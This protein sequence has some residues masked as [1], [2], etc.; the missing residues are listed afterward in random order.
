MVAPA[1]YVKL[2]LF[3]ELTGYTPKAVHRKKEEGH[4]LLGKQLR[5][6]PDGNLLVDMDEYYLWVEQAKQAA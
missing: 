4:W 6:A 3:E 1:K 5:M 2:Q